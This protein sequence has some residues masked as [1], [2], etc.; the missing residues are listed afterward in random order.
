MLSMAKLREDFSAG[1]LRRL[2]KRSKDANQRRRV[3][4]WPIIMAAESLDEPAP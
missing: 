1:P 4:N 2:A 3:P